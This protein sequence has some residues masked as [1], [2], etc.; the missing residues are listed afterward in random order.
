MELTFTS[1]KIVAILFIYLRHNFCYLMTDVSCELDE[2]VF[3]GYVSAP[4]DVLPS[5]AYVTYFFQ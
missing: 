5:A 4:C 3:D 1:N 2:I